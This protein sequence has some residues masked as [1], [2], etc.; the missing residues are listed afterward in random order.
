M[1]R[2]NDFSEKTVDPNPVV[3]FRI[4][5]EE[6]LKSAIA[7]P[8]SVSLATA[9]SDGRVSVRTVLLKDYNDEGF[10]FYTNYKSRKGLQLSS[11]PRAAL[12][13]YWPESARQVRLEGI[14]E[15]ISEEDSDSYFKT[16]PR[17]SQLSAWASEQSSVIP[18]R[19]H[20]ENR[21]NY[22]EN[23]LS[24]RPVDKPQQWGG[25]RIIPDWFEFWQEGEFRLHDRL[26]Y[27]KRKDLWSLKRLSP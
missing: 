13:F 21:Y 12:L 9:S 24:G 11:N 10:F 5:Y 19:Q 14:T 4:W 3:Q 27:T 6:R 16:R 17:E 23:L 26:T 7:I 18:D 1:T 25:F 15:K 22:Y 20:L 2:K 8:D